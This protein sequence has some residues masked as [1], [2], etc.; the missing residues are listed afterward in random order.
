MPQFPHLSSRDISEAALAWGSGMPTRGDDDA[1]TAHTC[2]Q[3]WRAV[4]TRV[5]APVCPSVYIRPGSRCLS[6][7]DGF[8]A[9]FP[10]TSINRGHQAGVH[11]PSYPAPPELAARLGKLRPSMKAGR[12]TPPAEERG[13]RVTQAPGLH[14]PG[15]AGPGGRLQFR[16]TRSRPAARVPGDR[17]T[18]AAGPRGQADPPPRIPPVTAP[19]RGPVWE[20]A[21][22]PKRDGS[23]KASLGGTPPTEVGQEAGGPAK[24]CWERKT[25]QMN[26]KKTKA[27]NRARGTAPGSDPRTLANTPSSSVS[28]SRAGAG[29]PDSSA[30]S[31]RCPKLGGRPEAESR[32]GG[33]VT[34]APGTNQ[35]PQEGG[36]TLRPPPRP[37]RT[38]R[39]AFFVPLSALGGPRTP[40]PPLQR[41]DPARPA[42][43]L[44]L[45]PLPSRSGPGLVLG[46][47]RGW[48][49]LGAPQARRPE[50]GAGRRGLNAP[51][52]PRQPRVA[53][54][55][56]MRAPPPNTP[57]SRPPAC[58][59]PP[60]WAQIQLPSGAAA[61]PHYCA[62]YGHP[63]PPPPAQNLHPLRCRQ[64]P[65]SQLHIQAPRQQ[66]GP[67]QLRCQE[68]P[69][70]G[71]SSGAQGP[72][73]APEKRCSWSPIT[74]LQTATPPQ[75]QPP[76]Q[77]R[78]RRI[79]ALAPE[80]ATPANNWAPQLR[81]DRRPP[82]SAAPAPS[83]T[84]R[85]AYLGAAGAASAREGARGREGAA[86]GPCAH[87]SRP[88]GSARHPGAEGLGALSPPLARGAALGG[89]GSAP[90]PGA[91]AS[92]PGGALRGGRAGGAPRPHLLRPPRPP[93]RLAA[94]PP[95]PPSSPPPQTRAGA[96]QNPARN[97]GR[98]R[99]GGWRRW[100]RRRDGG[101]RIPNRIHGDDGDAAAS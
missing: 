19:P 7:H 33:H 92:A 24:H 29:V 25:R 10:R 70:D 72:N 26:L 75:I 38:E 98:S 44:P 97:G 39:A 71:A 1:T 65:P 79:L 85:G 17:V 50:R 48:R 18:A 69:Q 31:G 46:R 59:E 84:P 88:A 93:L 8:L 66:S 76:P 91:P 16:R 94:P 28:T 12:T 62:S 27:G 14:L 83:R 100:G 82:E 52:P 13:A 37:A 5:P 57:P 101:G 2:P 9:A 6:P 51:G 34:P 15:R 64:E 56:A 95:P 78:C 99:V 23:R 87:L 43:S 90:V 55:L 74:P 47:A 58:P 61:S 60:T 35:R 30:P 45:R 20:A 4:R 77:M 22:I 36:H 40:G 54:V 42:V 21:G 3:W 89:G 67:P 86:G 53:P 41:G 68:T 80:P 73:P 81:A 63:P 96:A 32:T 11:P 49:G